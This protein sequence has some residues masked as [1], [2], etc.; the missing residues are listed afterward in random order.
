MSNPEWM[1]VADVAKYFGVQMHTV[2]RLIDDGKLPAQAGAKTSLRA[3]G[4]VRP[5]REGTLVRRA[6]LHAFL[7]ASRVKPGELRH[8]NP[9]L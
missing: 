4:E 3:N 1:R 8:L 6:D 9:R 7:E 2:Y 5:R